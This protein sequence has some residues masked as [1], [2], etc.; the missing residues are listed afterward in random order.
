M[1]I[2]GKKLIDMPVMSLQ[3]GSPLGWVKKVYIDPDDLKI[4]VLELY[5]PMIGKSTERY[6]ETRSIREYSEYG[7]IVDSVDDLFD[8]IDSEKLSHIVNLNYDIVGLK[9][10]ALNRS[11][12]GRIEDYTVTSDDL[13]IQQLVVKRPTW[14]SLM[15]SELLIPRK[16]IAEVNNKAVIVKD[17]EKTIKTKAEEDFVPNYVNPF[18]KN[19]APAESDFSPAHSQNPDEEDN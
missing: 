15:D 17:D 11:H 16:E 10:I 14:K 8:I 19:P 13:M 2:S 3:T 1:L 4:P 5:G 12:L 18:R 6:V 9:V 7:F